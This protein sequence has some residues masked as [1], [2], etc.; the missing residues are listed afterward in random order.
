M[1]RHLDTG[2]AVEDLK[3]RTLASLRGDI[4]RLVYLTA[5]RDCNTGKYYHD[6]LATQFTEEIADLALAE[7]HQEIFRK[8]AE[9][10]LEE[11]VRQ[12]ED[13]VRASYSTDEIIQTWSKLEPYRLMV[14]LICDRLS[15]RLFCSNF[16]IAL[17]ILQSRAKNRY[18]N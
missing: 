6:G 10:P 3:K 5:T 12:L 18:R 16:T 4:S 1:L 9:A 8:L 17:A 14:P 2:A 7:C 11:I 13:Y 15:A